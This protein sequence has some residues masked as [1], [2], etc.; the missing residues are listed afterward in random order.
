MQST[1]SFHLTSVSSLAELRFLFALLVGYARL[2]RADELS[3]VR[4]EDI[5]I[6]E[7]KMIIFIPKRK[8]D[9]Y[10]EGHFSY[11]YKSGEVTCPVSITQQLINV[12]PAER[13]SPF[14]VIRRIIN[15]KKSKGFHRA[16]RIFT[17]R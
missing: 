6:E 7:H 2:F 4:Y 10:R 9:K 15:E 12:L 3:S 11:I 13:D 8:N 5:N 14:P 17:L 1:A 16:K